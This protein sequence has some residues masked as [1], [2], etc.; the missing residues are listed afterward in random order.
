MAVPSR[1]IRMIGRRPNLSEMEP[2]NIA[3]MRWLVGSY[4]YISIWLFAAADILV[5]N[6]AMQKELAIQPR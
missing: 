5:K 2:Q 4:L 3:K 6:W 1:P